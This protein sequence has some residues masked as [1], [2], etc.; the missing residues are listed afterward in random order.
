MCQVMISVVQKKVAE[1]GRE[2]PPAKVGAGKRWGQ[3]GPGLPR[4][5]F[6]PGPVLLLIL[7]ADGLQHL[8]K[9]HGL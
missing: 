4:T 8:V 5:R 7:F 6:S 3:D 9:K 1:K 2:S